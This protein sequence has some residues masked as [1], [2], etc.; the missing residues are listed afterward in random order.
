VTVKIVT[1]S[2]G[3]ISP[4]IVK[5][6]GITVVPEY[7]LFG[8]KTYRDGIDISYDKLYE[9]L[10]NNPKLP[11]TSQPTPADFTRVYQEV[12][13]ETDEIISIHLSGKLS[14]TSSSAL[15]G[16]KPVDTKCNIT[17]IDSKS[18]TMGLGMLVMSAARLALRN[19][20]PE[21]I[22]DEITKEMNNIHLFATFDT[23]KY[24]A[25]GGRIGKAR[26]LF[27]SILNVKPIITLRDGVFAPVGNFRT[28]TKAID[29]LYELA[30]NY[31]NIQEI[32][33][34]YSTTPDDANYLIDRLSSLVDNKCLHLARLGPALG[35]HGGPGTLA[36]VIRSKTNENDSE[37]D[38]SNLST[39]KIS[40]PSIHLPKLKLPSHR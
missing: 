4:E 2:T 26:A 29:K 17:V 38:A 36:V 39:K 33:V 15:Q 35:V 27:G 19:E 11:S 3:D 6:L 7:V 37:K 31:L 28:R 20:K 8:D 12:A 16:K 1:D 30:K 40:G 10:I 13:K 32:A 5:E 14:G 18:V 25:L 9:K 23:L 24:L 22:V 21:I 34:I